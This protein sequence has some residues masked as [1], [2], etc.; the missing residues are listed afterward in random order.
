MNIFIIM[1]SSLSQAVQ[2]YQPYKDYELPPTYQGDFH[3]NRREER[4][5][6]L[7][8]VHT[9]HNQWANYVPQ[10]YTLHQLSCPPVPSRVRA[11][12][13]Q[14]ESVTFI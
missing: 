5:R 6:F 11:Q 4:N 8:E 14:L 2:E 3:G 9:Y 1:G 10:V 13:S 7:L 12:L